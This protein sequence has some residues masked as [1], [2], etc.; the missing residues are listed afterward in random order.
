[1]G[2]FKCLAK[3]C[4]FKESTFELKGSMRTLCSI[5]SSNRRKTRAQEEDVACSKGPAGAEL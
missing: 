2:R 4:G 3:K 1:M 5:H